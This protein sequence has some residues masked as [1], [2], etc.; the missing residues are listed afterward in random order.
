MVTPNQLTW[1]R[2]MLIPL[3]IVC[4]LINFHHHF[5]FATAVFVLA[6][7]TDWLD[8]YLARLYGQA[9]RFG[10]FLDPV[11]DKLLV[12]TACLLV[13]MHYHTAWI[14]L[15]IIMMMGREITILAL[16]EWMACIGQHMKMRVLY[17]AKVKTGVQL[18]A[19]TLLLMGFSLQHLFFKF[20][21]SLLYIATLFTLYSMVMYLKSAKTY[22][23]NDL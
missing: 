14:T 18:L 3:L 19:L 20:G 15:P 1:F 6:A 13:V 7:C 21:V 10:A 11:A 5:Y 23:T 4:Y 17:I 12:V 22:L 2:V 8:G 16:R 9:S